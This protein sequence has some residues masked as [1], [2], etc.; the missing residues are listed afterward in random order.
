M[1]QNVFVAVVKWVSSVFIHCRCICTLFEVRLVLLSRKPNGNVYSYKVH[2]SLLS[3]CI[4]HP[5]LACT[6]LYTDADVLLQTS[7]LHRRHLSFYLTKHCYRQ[8]FG[9]MMSVFYAKSKFIVQWAVHEII[10]FECC[11]T[12]I[13]Y[14][15]GS[16]NFNVDCKSEIL[17]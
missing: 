17:S 3:L 9:S 7:T 14:W 12:Q 4:L 16:T 10:V 1:L 11:L 6:I 15:T 8:K 13:F 2:I 5:A